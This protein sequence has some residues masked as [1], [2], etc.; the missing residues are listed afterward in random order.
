MI[1]YQV[2]LLPERVSCSFGWVEEALPFGCGT[3]DV[4][5]DGNPGPD[6]IID[7]LLP[8]KITTTVPTLM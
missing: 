8:M 3:E 5:I 2:L 7:D 4:Q 1:S 6:Q